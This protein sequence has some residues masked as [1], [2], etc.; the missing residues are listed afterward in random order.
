MFEHVYSEAHAL[1]DEQAAFL[2]SF[3]DPNMD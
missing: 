3:V 2:A 1:M